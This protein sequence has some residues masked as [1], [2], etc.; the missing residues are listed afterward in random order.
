MIRRPPLYRITQTESGPKKI[1]SLPQRR[2]KLM[3]LSKSAVCDIGTVI[4]TPVGASATLMTLLESDRRQIEQP[5]TVR[6]K[7]LQET[8]AVV[9]YR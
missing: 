9:S 4:G 1:L 8:Q 3:A 5:C 6:S 2:Q 7:R